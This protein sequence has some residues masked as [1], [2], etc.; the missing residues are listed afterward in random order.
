MRNAQQFGIG[1][2]HARPRVAIVIEHV[3]AGRVQFRIQ[4]RRP[5][6]RTASERSWL[7]VTQQHGE[8]RDGLGPDDSLFIMILFNGRRHD[9]RHTNAVAAHQRGQGLAGRVEHR[10]LHGLAVLAAQ[11]EDMTH[12]DAAADGQRARA[13]GAGV[14]GHHIAQVGDLRARAGRGPSSRR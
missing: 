4:A 13:G 9:A 12:L 11:L 10:G 3:D 7:R 14:A 6:V 2:L 1:E 5:A 8:G